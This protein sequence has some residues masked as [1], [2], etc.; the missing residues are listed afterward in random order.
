MGLD[1]VELV[2]D[3]EEALHLRIPDARAAQLATPRDVVRYVAKRRPLRREER[4]RGR[5]LFF[6]LRRALAE[7]EGWD[8]RSLRLD[9]PLL[10]AF[11]RWGTIYDELLSR[12]ASYDW[13]LHVPR[14][15]TLRELV[16]RLG[17]ALIQ[18]PADGPWSME[19]LCYVV[20]RTVEGFTGRGDYRSVHTFVGDMQLD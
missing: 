1:T 15:K 10:I 18:P 6:E 8:A 12:C 19:E 11:W 7:L 14:P 17:C 13:P 3:L 9:T 16:H 2:M 4:C 20:R 5:E